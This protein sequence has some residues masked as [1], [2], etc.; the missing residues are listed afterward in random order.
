MKS[1]YSDIEEYSP[2]DKICIP[3]QIVLYSES[4]L[5]RMTGWSE[6]AIQ[7][8]F[9]DPQFPVVQHGRRRLVERNA[10]I[11]YFSVKRS[12]DKGSKRRKRK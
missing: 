8:L 7:R 2:L 5:V 3:G 6:K 4:D 1:S 9:N 12:K 10:L 11:S